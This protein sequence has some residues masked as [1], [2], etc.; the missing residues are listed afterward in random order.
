MRIGKRTMKRWRS[1][2]R[3]KN[4]DLPTLHF[5][6]FHGLRF[7]KRP[8]TTS[9]LR[10]ALAGAS[11]LNLRNLRHIDLITTVCWL[12]TVDEESDIICLVHYTTQEYFDQTWA[13]FLMARR[14]LQ[15]HVLPTYH[16]VL[17]RLGTVTR[18]KTLRQDYSR[19]FCMIML[20]SPCRRIFN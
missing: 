12:V 8:L 4:R 11:T 15:R 13:G 7:S 17:L 3:V 18:M 1:E 10:H 16:L 2:L 6:L 20:G 19:I 14:I 9:E 5:G